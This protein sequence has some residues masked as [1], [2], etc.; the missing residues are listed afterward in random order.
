M[1]RTQIVHRMSMHD[2]VAKPSIGK[3]KKNNNLQ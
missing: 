2:T 3:A 1:M